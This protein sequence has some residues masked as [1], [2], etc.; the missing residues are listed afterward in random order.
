METNTSG[1]E[2]QQ[3]AR[4]TREHFYVDPVSGESKSVT[5]EQEY[6]ATSNAWI[7]P[8]VRVTNGVVTIGPHARYI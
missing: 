6:D 1:Q 7:W 2:P 4:P 8:M 5:I 3:T